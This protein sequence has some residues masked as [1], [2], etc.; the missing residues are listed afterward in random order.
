MKIP[1]AFLLNKRT[2]DWRDVEALVALDSPRA[3]VLLRKALKSRNHEIATAVISY[4]PGLLTDEER[5]TALV[6]ALESSRIYEGLTQTLLE[7][8]EFHLLR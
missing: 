6:A 5:T 1:E 2:A 3:R 4:A 7:V 8:E